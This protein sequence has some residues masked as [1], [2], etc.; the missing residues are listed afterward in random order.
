MGKRGNI[1]IS[2]SRIGRKKAPCAAPPGAVT[3]EEA[4]RFAAAAA[5]VVRLPAAQAQGYAGIGTLREK[6]LH[7]AVKRYLSP[8]ATGQEVPV[9][10]LGEAGTARDRI[11]DVRLP[12]GHIFEVQTGGFY[13]LRRKIGLYMAH[14]DSPVTVV[15]PLPYRKYLSWIDPASG[16]ILSRRRSPRHADVRSAARELYWLSDWIGDPRLTVS[17]LFLELEEFRM[18]DGWGRDGKRGSNRYERIPTAL[19][20]R[21]DLRTPADYAAYFLPQEP[22]AFPDGYFTAAGYARLTGIRGRTTYG[23][24]H[25]LEKLELIREDGMEGRSRR[26]R[27]EAKSD[28]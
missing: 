2:R 19:C 20:G 4:A 14:T 7:M 23:I 16:Q 24:L 26:Y 3:A 21:V 10:E 9:R 11:A 17:L 28:G 6:R 12:D 1:S 18:Q 8:D 25:L 5:E 22:T 13:P 15:H 27:L